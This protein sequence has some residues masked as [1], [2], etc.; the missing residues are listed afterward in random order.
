MLI[1]TRRPGES[2]TLTLNKELANE[3]LNKGEVSVGMI[4]LGINGNQARI[5]TDA[6]KCVEI[7][8]T[9]ILTRPNKGK[10]IKN[11]EKSENKP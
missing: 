8:R 1:L 7:A 3:I 2:I 10:K 9:E 6:P 5:G 4:V 11:N